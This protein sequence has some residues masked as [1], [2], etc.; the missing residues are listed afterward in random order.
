MSLGRRLS[1]LLVALGA[2]C[3]GQRATYTIS[4]TVSGPVSTAVNVNLTGDVTATTVTTAAGAFAFDGL[5]PG[6]YVVTPVLAGYL[7]DPAE[8]RVVL[9]GANS[10]LQGFAI[11]KEPSLVRIGGGI[12]GTTTSGVAIT[13]IGGAI[14]RSATSDSSGSFSFGL[15]PDGTY[16]LSASAPA[17]S[18]VPSARTVTTHQNDAS[19]LFVATPPSS[20]AVIR[21]AGDSASG[22]AT[23]TF[24][25]EDSETPNPDVLVYDPPNDSWTFN[26]PFDANGFT[27]LGGVLTVHGNPAV[28]TYDET[29]AGLVASFGCWAVAPATP[30]GQEIVTEFWDPAHFSLSLDSVGA[31]VA[32]NVASTNTNFTQIFYPVHGSFHADC[33][34]LAG[35]AAQGVVTLDATF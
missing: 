2:A 29:T 24:P 16:T 19:V 30:P 3:G 34:A 21:V 35:S 11:A 1:P 17:W 14:T 22:V 18:F 12:Q 25:S 27:G 9:S 31:P 15:V 4:G 26:L 20:R 8:R 33:P 32:T 23:G 6:S 10:P 28:S 7:F 13:M 5:P